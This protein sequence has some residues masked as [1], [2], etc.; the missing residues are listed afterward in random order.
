MTT[1]SGS[2]SS[3]PNWALKQAAEVD[4]EY[5]GVHFYLATIYHTLA[6]DSAAIDALEKERVA[7][8][9]NEDVLDPQLLAEPDGG[10]WRLSGCKHCV[11]YA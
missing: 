2:S 5:P 7:S 3:K 1:I 9:D 6:Q 8:P 11:P 10:G 4:P